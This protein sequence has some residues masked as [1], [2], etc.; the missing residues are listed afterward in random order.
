MPTN[1]F[2]KVNQLWHMTF[3]GTSVQLPEVKGFVDLAVLLARPR[4]EAHCTQLM[5]IPVRMDDGERVIDERARREYET[6][7]RD[8]QEAVADAEAMNDLGRRESLE[9]ELDELTAHLAK[10]LGLGSR[11]RTVNTPVDRARSAVTW[12]VRSAIRKIE[13]AHPSLGRHL[14]HSVRTG[15]FC[16]YEPEKEQIW[17]L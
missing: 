13:T 3:E 6:R 11:T 7:I 14:S 8:L 9:A 12:R 1:V 4:V 16:C 10:A 15:T 17:R 5:G 2:R